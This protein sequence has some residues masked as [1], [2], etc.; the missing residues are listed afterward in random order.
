MRQEKELEGIE[1]VK[2]KVKLSLFTDMIMFTKNPEE[3]TK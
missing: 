3:A 1:I 2:E